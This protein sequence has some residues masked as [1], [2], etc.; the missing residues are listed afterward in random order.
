MFT[1]LPIDCDIM[2]KDKRSQHWDSE[3]FV[4]ICRSSESVQFNFQMMSCCTL[5]ESF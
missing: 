5:T 1:I 4:Y 2:E 3:T